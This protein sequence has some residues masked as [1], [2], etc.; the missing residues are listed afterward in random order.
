MLIDYRQIVL[1]A[2]Q[3][4]ASGEVKRA[5]R[6][7]RK[8]CLHDF[9]D[10]LWQLPLVEFP[11]LSQIL[12]RMASEEIQNAWT[13]ASGIQMLHGTLDF[14]RIMQLQYERICR[15]PMQQARILDYGCGYGRLARMM[16][17]FSDPEDYFGVDPWERSIEIC[18]DDGLLGSIK[19]S[20]YLPS[21]LPVGQAQFDLIFSYS[22]FTHTSLR[23]TNAGL[24]VLRDYIHSNGLLVITV[25]PVDFWQVVNRIPVEE[26]LAQ[27]A[28]HQ[29]DG[30]AYV[31][32]SF[33]VIEGEVAFG[34]TSMTA[35]WI[36]RT[37]PYWRVEGY[38]RGIDRWQTILML[39]PR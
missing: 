13:G 22:V 11:A 1:Q 21:A 38:D 14:T 19:Q 9:G 31:P 10:F 33:P 18:R 16:Y 29:R 26:R 23:T 25:R 2:E 39:S 24:R 20:D 30:F 34:D 27:T 8:L 4:A 5:L 17:W 3:E 37:H 12:P 36:E 6:Q 15:R 28:L 7:L 32:D 35:A